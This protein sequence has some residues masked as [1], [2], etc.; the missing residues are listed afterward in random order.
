MSRRDNQDIRCPTCHM[1]NTLCVC[2]LVPTLTTR[3]RLALLVHYREARKPTNTGQLAARCLANSQVGIVGDLGRPLTLPLWLEDEQPVLLFPAEDAAPLHTFATCKKPIVL[4]VPDGNWRQAGK[5][6]QR[7]FGLAEVPC[8]LLPQGL[9]T[10]YR[11]RAEPRAGG[12]ATMEAIAYALGVLEGA[13]GPHIQ[14]EMM[15]VF[16]IMVE[17]TLWLRGVLPRETVTGGIPEAAQQQAA[18]GAVVLPQL[19][20]VT[21]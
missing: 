8:A 18:R 11:L 5:M 17:R 1:H 19:R 6:R 13:A 12:L 3:T 7:V 20:N 9:A 4:I 21:P 16:R 14:Q 2:P 10:S 15:K